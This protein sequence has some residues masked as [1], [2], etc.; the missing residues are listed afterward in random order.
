MDA[1]PETVIGV[2]RQMKAQGKGIIGM[3]ILGAGRLRNK[4]D[5]CLQF[6]LSLDCVDCFTIGA[7]SREEMLDLVAKIPAASVRG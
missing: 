5:E 4:V 2:L 7:E 3:K 1:D 6:A